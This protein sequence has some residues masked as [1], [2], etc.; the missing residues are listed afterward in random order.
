MTPNTREA[1]ARA[2]ARR[3][4]RTLIERWRA[5]VIIAASVLVAD[6][7]IKLIVR[8]TMDPRESH[9]IF[10]GFS[11]TRVTN[12]GIAFGLFP[13]RQVAVAILTVVA[14]CGIIIAIVAL[15][16]RHRG[17]ATGGGLL[18]GGSL[19]NLIDRLLHGGVTDYL[20]PA[21]WPAFN[22]A[23]MAIVSGAALIALGL[24]SPDHTGTKDGPEP[25]WS[26]R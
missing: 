23:D 8:A 25:P 11:I 13:G 16:R 9:P 12:T 14:L 10:P 20:D 4:R 1:I 18:M 7:I 5:F 19:G 15:M 26:A 6:Q 3:T 22:L 2:A 17:V 21:R 24:L